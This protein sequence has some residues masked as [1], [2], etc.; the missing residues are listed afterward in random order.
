MST[1]GIQRELQYLKSCRATEGKEQVTAPSLKLYCVAVLNRPHYRSCPSVCFVQAPISKTG[2]RRK[3]E[4]GVKVPHGSVTDVRPE[5]GVAPDSVGRNICSTAVHA[6]HN[7][8][9]KTYG[10]TRTQ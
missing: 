8:Q 9:L 10:T 6:Q 3:T 2:K 7:L 5:C 1:I 4:T